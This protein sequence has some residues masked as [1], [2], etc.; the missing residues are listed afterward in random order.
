MFLFIGLA[1]TDGLA[2]QLSEEPDVLDP[3]RSRMIESSQENKR[4]AEE[5]KALKAQLISLQLEIEQIE[6]E[7]KRL[8]PGYVKMSEQERKQNRESSGFRGLGDDDLIR[9]AQNIYLS[10]RTMALGDVE[11]LKELQLYDLQYRKQEL[12][13]DLMSMEF[14]CR[15]VNEQRQPEIEAQEEGIKENEAKIENISMQIIEEERKSLLYPRNIELLKMENKALRQKI[16]NLKQL[17]KR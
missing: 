11:R 12:E 17:M 5:N 7:M 16:R 10:G 3:I 6:G 9:E 8:D 15:K 1:R 14:L 2:E 13:L 4:L